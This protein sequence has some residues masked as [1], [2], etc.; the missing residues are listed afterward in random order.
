[1]GRMHLLNRVPGEV[2]VNLKVRDKQD[3]EEKKEIFGEDRKRIRKRMFF[4]NVI[5]TA[6][7]LQCSEF[8]V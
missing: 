7:S 5:C 6:T 4:L 3:S 2:F 1:M 8:E